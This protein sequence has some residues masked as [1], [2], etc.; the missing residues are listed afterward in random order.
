M[1]L[2][3]ASIKATRYT[4][5]RYNYNACFIEDNTIM[6]TLGLKG[7]DPLQ[8]PNYHYNYNK[9]LQA[10]IYIYI[11]EEVCNWYLQMVVIN[12]GFSFKGLY[13]ACVVSNFR[14]THF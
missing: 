14:C 1:D 8:C 6:E 3:L 4:A 9:N 10:L 7:Y 5:T 11:Y 13:L 12:I 2:H